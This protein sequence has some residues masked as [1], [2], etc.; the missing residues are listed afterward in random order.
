MATA[1]RDAR[2]VELF[3][4]SLSP[5][6]SPTTPHVRR[7]RSLEAAGRIESVTVLVWGR[8]LGL[9]RT[10]DRTATGQFFLDRIAAFRVWA[11]EHEVTLDP[12]FETREVDSSITGE[13]YASLLLPVCCLAEY[14]DDQLRHVTPHSNGC[15]I[16]TVAD[17]LRSLDDVEP[18]GDR[19][20]T[21]VRA[22]R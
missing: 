1:T 11:D 5:A 14:E 13:R 4:R 18:A 20:D 16:R 10:A 6:D 22:P 15:A 9:S 8:E 17:R 21:M 2:S 3:V 12:F 7:L 19:S